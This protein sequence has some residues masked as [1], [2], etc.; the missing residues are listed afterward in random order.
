MTGKRKD[1]YRKPPKDYQWQPGQSGNPKGRPRRPRIDIAKS[2]TEP[3]QFSMNG[4][5]ECRSPF[6]AGLLSLVA[7]AAKGSMR[8]AGKFLSYCGS[9]GLL[10]KPEE[11][12]DHQYRLEIPKDWK[13]DEWMENYNR[14]GAPPWKGERDGLTETVR[15][16]RKNARRK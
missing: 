4:R 1:N 11:T 15:R 10:E 8:A 14:F 6:E 16:E 3:I 9:A 5:E 12:D 7:K 13:S 2:L